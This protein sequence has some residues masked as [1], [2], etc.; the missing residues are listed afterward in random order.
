MEPEKGM[1]RTCLRLLLRPIAR[2]CLRH[3]LHIQDLLEESKVAFLDAAQAELT[4][5]EGKV[6]VARLS[7][8]TGIHRRDVTRIYENEE[9]KDTGLALV[10]RVIGQWQQDPRF[11]TK[12]RKP[13]VLSFDGE[14]SDFRKLVAAVSQ[15]LP[16]GTI[17]AELE[18]IGAVE[19]SREGIKL[20]SRLY[21]TRGNLKQT[22]AVVGSDIDDLLR[23]VE[24]NVF[25]DGSDENLHIKTQYDRIALDAVPKIREWIARE[26]SAL[27]Q[28]A[29]NFIS[30]YDL[31]INPG[32][33]SADKHC[34]V[35]LGSFSF[36]SPPDEDNPI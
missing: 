17:L 15:E 13:R 6:S 36:I 8:M 5:M 4:R 25:G 11:L 1:F 10:S 9:T 31:D 2:F 3:S 16:A 28:K 32:L 29:R 21:V 35:A 24:P 12:A 22:M 30:Q 23:G 18:R 19:Q 14:E 27:H 33:R 34:R 26:G 7:T 20:V